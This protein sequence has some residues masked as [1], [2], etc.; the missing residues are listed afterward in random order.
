[1]EPNSCPWDGFASPQIDFCE[2]NLCG[3]LVE[4]ANAVSSLAF[5]A[6]GIYLLKRARKDKTRGSLGLVGLFSILIGVFSFL[7]HATMTGW[8]NFLDLTSMCVLGAVM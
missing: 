8:G 2:R 5:C 1:M 4:P 7:F 3:W 6:V